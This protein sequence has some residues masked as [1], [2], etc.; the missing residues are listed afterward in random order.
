[1]Y[2]RQEFRLHSK[3]DEKF[4]TAFIK[5]WESYY[6]QLK[7]QLEDLPTEPVGSKDSASSKDGQWVYSR[8]LGMSMKREHLEF[9]SDEQIGQL[10]SLKEEAVKKNK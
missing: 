8:R 10:H 2:I 3:A 5:E 9:L 4:S 7:S 1:M 6:L